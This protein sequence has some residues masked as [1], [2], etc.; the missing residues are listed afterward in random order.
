[1]I[2]GLTPGQ[3]YVFV[4]TATNSVGRSDPSAPSAVIVPDV[5]PTTP[6]PP[7]VEYRARGEVSVSWS[8]PTGD[9]TPVSVMSLQVLLGDQ[10]VQELD[11]AASPTVLSGLDSTGSYQFRVRAANQQGFSDWSAAS[12]AIV[13]SGVPSAPTGLSA[14]FVYR[15]GPA[16]RPGHLGPAGRRRRRSRPDV[17][18]AG[19]QQRGRLRGTRLALRVRSRRRQRSGLRLGDRPQPHAATAPRPARRPS[20]RSADRPR[21]PASR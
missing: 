21:S 10:V 1:M 16:R 2:G 17:P 8:V 13:P 5:T 12:G 7:S 3:A 18:A 20:L 4:L 15:R 11:S 19:Q 9:F 14:Q 6:A